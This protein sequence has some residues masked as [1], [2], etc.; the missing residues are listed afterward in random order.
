MNKNEVNTAFEILLEE[1]AA[2]PNQLN[3]SGAEAF[4]AGEYDQVRQAI[5]Q[6]TRLAD[7]REKIKALQRGWAGFAA[8][9]L[10][11]RRPK[12]R[13]TAQARLGRGLRT[14]ED[15]YRRPILESL[16]ELGGRAPVGEVLERVSAKMKDHLNQYDYETLASDPRLIRLKNTAHWCRNT[17]VREGLMKGDSPHGVWEIS[18]AGKRWL[19]QKGG[20]HG[21]DEREAS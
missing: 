8:G 10:K 14:P 20:H 15:A 6:A 13:Q 4:R 18:E 7:F 11:G 1:I 16:M 19:L 12:R 21:H 17:L 9:G 2:L 3:E 5:E